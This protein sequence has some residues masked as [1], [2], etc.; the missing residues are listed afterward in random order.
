MFVL[1]NKYYNKKYCHRYVIN[2]GSHI[3]HLFAFIISTNGSDD[4][5]EGS[6]DNGNGSEGGGNGSSGDGEG[7]GEDGGIFSQNLAVTLDFNTNAVGF[8]CLKDL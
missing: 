6:G 2:S 7:K 5:D 4:G 3:I 8:R 1:L